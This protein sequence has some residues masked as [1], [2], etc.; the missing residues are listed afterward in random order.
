MSFLSRAVI[1][2]LVL[3][4]SPIAF[5]ADIDLAPEPKA[6]APDAAVTAYNEGVRAMREKHYAEAQQR[7]EE[8]LAKREAF[9]EAHSNL[10]YVLRKQGHANFDASMRHYGRSIEINPRLA[11]AYMY[12][13]VLYTQMGDAAHA[14][15]DLATLKKLDPALAAKL[16]AAIAAGG[17]EDG[18]AGAVY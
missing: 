16:E 1:L 5:G 3:G 15:A 7:F 4:T 6:D 14:Q 13:G 10:A 18:D 2:V 8:A 11:Q 12:R 9:A 17:R